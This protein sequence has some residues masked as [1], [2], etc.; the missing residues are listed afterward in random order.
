MKTRI[1]TLVMI[2]LML[3]IN[4]NSIAGNDDTVKE[5]KPLENAEF[6]ACINLYPNDIVRFQV[7]KPEDEKVRLRVYDQEGYL[8]YTYWLKKY[9]SAKIGF[10]VSQLK[11]GKYDYVVERNKKEVLRK[12]IEKK[13]V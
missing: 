10:D 2:A 11:P 9:E 6:Q 1:L 12:R 5:T 7:I 3:G 4:L 13:G 8:I